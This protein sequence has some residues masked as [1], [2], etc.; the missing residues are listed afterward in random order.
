MKS[1]ESN[2]NSKASKTSDR[3][4][5]IQTNQPLSKVLEIIIFNKMS[6]IIETTQIIP[7]H[8]FGFR[9]FYSTIEQCNRVYTIA[10]SNRDKTS[11]EEIVGR[12]RL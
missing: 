11:K 9:K 7:D 10:R 4:M 1:C 5:L 8:Q 12:A 2:I 3:H 6:P